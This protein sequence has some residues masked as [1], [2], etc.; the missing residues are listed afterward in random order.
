MRWL[1]EKKQSLSSLSEAIIKEKLHELRV[2]HPG[3]KGESFAT[4][5]AAGANSAFLH[6]DNAS[7]TPFDA[8][9]T[10]VLLD[11]GAHYFDPASGV[12]GSPALC[13]TTDITRTVS[14][15]QPPSQTLIDAYTAAMKAHIALAAH[16]FDENT[17]SHDLDALAREQIT[18]VEAYAVREKQEH[19]D[20]QEL[21]GY[22]C[23]TGHGV[24]FYSDLHEL[25]PRISIPGRWTDVGLKEGMI[26]S[27]EPG[28]YDAKSGLGVRIE[29]LVAV[30]K[31]RD[32]KCQLENLTLA[33]F[34]MSLLDVSRLDV[35]EIAW[36]NDYHAQVRDALMPHLASEEQQWLAQATRP[37]GTWQHRAQS[38]HEAGQ[39]PQR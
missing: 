32:G 26:F 28:Y 21:F 7:T 12:D 3:F 20:Q 31:G 29:N 6:Y 8:S 16:R 18:S 9:T 2:Q 35:E 27:N 39:G 37:V 17:P 30:Q 10:H 15:N 36:L 24:G 38:S 14:I 33:P 22:D 13:G 4:I 11:C 19:P 23:A 1:D 34:D 5:A 25:P